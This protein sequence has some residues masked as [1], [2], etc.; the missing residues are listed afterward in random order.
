LSL[1]FSRWFGRL[2]DVNALLSCVLLSRTVLES[3][4]TTKAWCLCYWIA[5]DFAVYNTGHNKT[6]FLDSAVSTELSRSRVIRMGRPIS[7]ALIARAS[8]TLLLIDKHPVT[9]RFHQQHTVW[10]RRS[11]PHCLGLGV[12][13]LHRRAPRHLESRGRHSDSQ[14]GPHHARSP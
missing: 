13:P 1:S 2:V 12:R 4:S 7:S 11:Q 9:P 14:P 3:R 5:P 10:T 8:N 6:A